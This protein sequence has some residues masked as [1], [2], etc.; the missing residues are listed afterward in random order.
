MWMR[1]SPRKISSL[2]LFED[3]EKDLIFLFGL[4]PLQPIKSLEIGGI[5]TRVSRK[6]IYR[7]HTANSS[8]SFL[9]RS[10]FA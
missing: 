4:L 5:K 7:G 1:V 8:I 9:F 10:E 2:I 6:S 3:D